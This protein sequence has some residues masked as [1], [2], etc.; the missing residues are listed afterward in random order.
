MQ[1]KVL[2]NTA[3][4][5]NRRRNCWTVAIIALQKQLQRATWTRKA[6]RKDFK[7][8]CTTRIEAGAYENGYVFIKNQ[9]PNQCI[10]FKDSDRKLFLLISNHFRKSDITPIIC[11]KLWPEVIYI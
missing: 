1:R 4:L 9:T 8:L 5:Q 11:K 2:M 3:H 10:L 6:F 7:E